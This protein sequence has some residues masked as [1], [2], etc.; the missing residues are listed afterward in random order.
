MIM[1]KQRDFY[2]SK[3]NTIS[4]YKGSST[5]MG[6]LLYQRTLVAR[7]KPTSLYGEIIAAIFLADTPAHSS[8]GTLYERNRSCPKQAAHKSQH[9]AIRLDVN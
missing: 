2:F 1:W 9:C 8:S 4:N 5:R 6:K 7:S 3:S